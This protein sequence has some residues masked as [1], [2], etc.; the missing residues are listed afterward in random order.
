MFSTIQRVVTADVGDEP[1]R[2]LRTMRSAD[3][4]D[5]GEHALGHQVHHC[6]VR[7]F[8]G[9]EECGGSSHARGG[10]GHEHPPARDGSR[11][12]RE[13]HAYAHGLSVAAFCSV[14][15]ESICPH[16]RSPCRYRARK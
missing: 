3:L 11:Q 7:T 9:E 15:F 13:P 14:S 4:V 6:D 10:S 2:G 5:D 12:R 1:V 8:V 16:A